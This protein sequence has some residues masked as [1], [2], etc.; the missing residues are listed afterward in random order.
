[1]TVVVSVP[2][3]YIHSPSSV[4]DLNDIDNTIKLV[5]EFLKDVKLYERIS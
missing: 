4:A 1:M 3:R 2:C 5:Q